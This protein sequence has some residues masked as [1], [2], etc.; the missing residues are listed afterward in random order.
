MLYVL[1]GS[2]QMVAE[3]NKPWLVSVK[4][5]IWNV[6]SW[7]HGFVHMALDWRWSWRFWML[8]QMKPIWG[9]QVREGM[10][11][12]LCPTL[13]PSWSS[14]WSHDSSTT[15]RCRHILLLRSTAP[16]EWILWNREPR[17]CVLLLSQH[18]EVTNAA[19]LLSEWTVTLFLLPVASGS[20]FPGKL[21]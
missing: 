19:Q 15:S 2:Y 6:P 18:E 3:I 10:S 9:K 4:A 11:P 14:F 7:A 12:Q 20:A 1:R 16:M 5:W 21:C 13:V 17:K 8:W